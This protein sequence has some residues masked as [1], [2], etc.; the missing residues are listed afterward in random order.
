MAGKGIIEGHFNGGRGTL[1]D[2]AAKSNE[3]AINFQRKHAIPAP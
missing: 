2:L 1:A 3:A